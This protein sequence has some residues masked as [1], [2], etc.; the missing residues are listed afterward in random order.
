M[1]ARSRS[2]IRAGEDA[3]LR[4]RHGQR[5][6]AAE[7]IIEAH[8][9]APDQRVIGLVE[10]ANAVD[11]V[12]RALLQMVLQIAPDALAIE[13]DIDAERRQP[14]RRPD[15]G[16]MQHLHRSDRAGAQ[17]HFALGAGLDDLA[18]L[19]EAHAD[20][21]A[22]LDD[23]AIDQHVLFQPQI[24][25]VQHRLQKAAR[26]RPAP[27]ALLVDVEIAD[28]LIVAGVEIGNSSDAHFLRGIADRVEN[29][30]GQPRRLDPPAAAGAVM[31]ALAEEMILQP[32]EVP[33]ARRH[34]PSRSSP[35]WRQ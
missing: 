9:A 4:R 10:G 8:Q 31:L 20:R 28:A 18:A 7:G 29:G 3:E 35:S 26:R 11:L 30:P 22:V 2:R 21:A 33:A 1:L 24:G 15:A 27:S 12:D 32:P 16:A 25:A 19:H 17:D 6:A 13:H 14:V 5:P 23:Q 34:S